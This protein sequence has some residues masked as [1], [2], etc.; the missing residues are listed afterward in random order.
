MLEIKQMKWEHSKWIP[1]LDDDIC[2]YILKNMHARKDGRKR[3]KV[4]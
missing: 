2:D 1:H 3:I 4:L